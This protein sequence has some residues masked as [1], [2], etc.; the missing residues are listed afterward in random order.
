MHMLIIITILYN[1]VVTLR[2]NLH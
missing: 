2:V 1:F